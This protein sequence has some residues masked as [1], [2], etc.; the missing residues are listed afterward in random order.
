METIEPLVFFGQISSNEFEGSPAYLES[1]K[2]NFIADQ[3]TGLIEARPHPEEQLFFLF[4]GGDLVGTYRHRDNQSQPI[5][6]K[7][8]GIGWTTPTIPIQL[9]TLSEVAGR[10]VWL[11]LESTVAER[12][13]IS[14]PDGWQALLAT[15]HAQ[16]FTGQ[17]HLRSSAC[18]ALVLF[19]EGEPVPTETVSSTPRGFEVGLAAL[20]THLVGPVQIVLTTFLPEH[21]SAQYCALRLS[22]ARMTKKMLERYANLAGQRLLQILNDDLN[23]MISTWHWR[24]RLNGSELLDRH[25]FARLEDATHAYTLILQTM[26][27]RI[28]ATIGN[29]LMDNLLQETQTHLSPTLR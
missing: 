20:S 6:E 22:A 1:L 5:A 29:M 16:Q 28:Q 4:A 8:A 3:A 2:H 10:V 14:G 12:R 19:W 7:Q 26:R 21:P 15:L 13:Q 25:F 24:M 11:R 18:D 17:V 9:I 27:Q 23:R